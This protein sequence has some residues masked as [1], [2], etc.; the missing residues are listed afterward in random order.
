[1]TRKEQKI[2]VASLGAFNLEMPIIQ[3]G[4]GSPKLLIVNNLHG[5]ELTGFYALE[6][7]IETIPQDMRGTMTIIPTANPLGL[8]QKHR[9]L[10]LD[11][12]DL[13][14]GYPPAAKERG[15]HV[16]VRNVLTT[17]ADQHDII[18]DIHTFLR[19][20]LSAGLI[21]HQANEKNERLL[22]QCLDVL[23]TDSLIEIDAQG[24][25]EKRVRSAFGFYMIERGK[26]AFS[27]EYPPITYT[28]VDQIQE[29]ARGLV[30]LLSVLGMSTN[31]IEV[32]RV[33]P[34]YRRQ[35]MM[36]PKTALFIPKMNLNHKVRVG[37]TLGL[38]LDVTTLTSEPLISQYDGVLIEIAARQFYVCGEKLVTIGAVI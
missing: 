25:E 23:G 28:S 13:N 11:F 5:N 14:R 12:V 29:Y 7:F 6:R 21:F 35:Q 34:I 15:F 24:S 22:R 37:D 17:L 20:C 10:P 3:F 16:A 30:R 33:L 18:L 1:M 32:S 4:S 26:L 8:L 2:F 38:L 27:I 9:L 31:K 36:S 19:P